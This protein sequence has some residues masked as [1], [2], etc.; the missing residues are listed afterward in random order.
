ME[1]SLL[2]TKKLVLRTQEGKYLALYLE[3][4]LFDCQ[5]LSH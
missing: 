2:S 1:K 3:I 4:V 5:K